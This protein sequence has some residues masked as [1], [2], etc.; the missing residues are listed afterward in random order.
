MRTN[1]QWEKWA[2]V[3]PYFGVFSDDK[4]RKS[5]LDDLA[6]EDF[7]NSGEEHV[8]G[9]FEILRRNFSLN[10]QL[11][12]AF[13]FGCG[14]G[15]LVIPLAMRVESVTGVDI[16][17]EMLRISA[18]NSSLHGAKNVEFIL[19][20][21]RLSR[22]EKQFDLVH[23]CAVLQH[24]PWQ[25]GKVIFSSLVKIVKPGGFIATQFLI[26]RNANVIKRIFAVARYYFPPL[27]WIW[28]LMRSRGFSEPPMELHVYSLVYVLN[29]LF[30]QG[31]TQVHIEPTQDVGDDFSSILLIA[32]RGSF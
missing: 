4:Y 15:R 22:V 17:P 29:L 10:S 19:A 3:D 25:R 20:D 24:V 1:R 7:F 21:D 11:K 14:V 9:V 5:A 28:N 8:E 27:Q 16:S 30:K 2:A 18:E 32:K 31:F 12:C 13:D 23:S 26:G 6:M